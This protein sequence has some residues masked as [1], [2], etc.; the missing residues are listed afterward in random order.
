MFTVGSYRADVAVARL[1]MRRRRRLSARLVAGRREQVGG[2][3]GEGEVSDS[4]LERR[5]GVIVERCW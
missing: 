1:E 4:V 5:G 3:G 2:G